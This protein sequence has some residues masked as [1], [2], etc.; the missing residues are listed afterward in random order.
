MKKNAKTL[1]I[2]LIITYVSIFILSAGSICLLNY[3]AK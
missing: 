1:F 3:L 2:T